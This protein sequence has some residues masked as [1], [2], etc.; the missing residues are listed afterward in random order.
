MLN[1]RQVS[2]AEDPLYASASQLE[3]Q[4]QILLRTLRVICP[5]ILDKSTDFRQ[6]IKLFVF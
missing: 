3:A 5:I 2:S 1:H 4:T 6:N